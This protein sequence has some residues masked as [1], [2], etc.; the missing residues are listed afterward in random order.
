MQVRTDHELI[1]ETLNGNPQAFD[2]LM[3]RY[4]ETVYRIALGYGK[5]R[6]NA[7]DISQIVFLQVYRK[8][9]TFQGKAKFKTWLVRI[10]FNEGINWTKKHRR[11][12][13]T[14]PFE[15]SENMASANPSQE[16]TVLAKESRLQLLRSMYQ[17]NTRYRLAVVLR[18]F[19]EMPIRQIAETMKCSEGVVKNML[20]RSL[21]KM[22]KNLANV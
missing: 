22:R 16:Q 19:E 14:I 18:Y 10:A 9:A 2:S 4:Q 1:A 20:F 7:L 12:M 21:Q 5:T 8:L 15:E 17:L 11:Q 13:E 6:E 3:A